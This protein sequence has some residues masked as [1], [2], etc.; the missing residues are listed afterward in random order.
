MIRSSTRS[1]IRNEEELVKTTYVFVAVLALLAGARDSAAQEQQS[2]KTVMGKGYDIKS[3]VF[4]K[5]EATENREAVI[6]TLQKE[7]S[8]A[9]CFFWAPNWIS[10]TPQTLDDGK[11]CDVR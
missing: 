8:V 4:T 9:V 11:R 1:P 10:L 5:G 2:F 7:K 3:V 6:V